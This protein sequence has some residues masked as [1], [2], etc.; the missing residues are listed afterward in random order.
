MNEPLSD[1]IYG[2]SR[3]GGLARV[4][5]ALSKTGSEAAW[6]SRPHGK[7]I[8]TN[9]NLD[10]LNVLSDKCQHLDVTSRLIE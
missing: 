3:S 6:Q 7:T 2:D 10:L 9:L 5:P 4:C 8:G 1:F